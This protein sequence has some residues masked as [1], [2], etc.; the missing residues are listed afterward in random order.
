MTTDKQQFIDE[1]VCDALDMGG[2]RTP[3]EIY[4]DAVAEWEG[5]QT[6]K[7]YEAQRDREMSKL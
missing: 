2:S 7:A 1:Y 6:D 4:D 5:S 3:D